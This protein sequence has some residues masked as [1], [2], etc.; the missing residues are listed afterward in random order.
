MEAALGTERARPA[1]GG[2]GDE[3]G[4]F[5]RRPAF[6]AGTAL[7]VLAFAGLFFRW[8][9]QQHRFS[10]KSPSDWG[11]AYLIP[12][13]SCYLLWQH[14]EALGRARVRPN[15]LGLVVLA[16]GILSHFAFI[17][18]FPNHMFQG[19]ALV[20]S[21]MGVTLLM[22]GTEVMRHAFLPIAY[23]GFG[24][25]LS[26]KLMIMITFKLQAVASWGAWVLLSVVSPLMGFD[27]QRNG[28]VL[29]VT[30]SAGVTN[31]LNV[32]EQCSGMRMVVAFV[33]LGTAV[34]LI[35][36]RKWWRRIVVVLSAIPVA[37]FLNVVRVA[38]LGIVTLFDPK[39]A[40]GAA[41]TLIGTI[42]LIPGL[43]LFLLIVWILNRIVVDTGS[44]EGRVAWR[45]G[46][47]TGPRRT[48]P[49]LLAS[50]L[51]LGVSATA[52]G[53]AIDAMEIRLQKL[54]VHPESG[55]MLKAIPAET[56]NWVRLGRDQIQDVEIL[57]TLG[58]ENEV[59][60]TYQEKHA[61]EGEKPRRVEFHAT[62][63]TGMIDT[64]PHV[65]ERCFV[66][67]GLQIV[68]GARV[69]PLKLD[70][71]SWMRDPEA[72]EVHGRPMFRAWTSGG[73]DGLTGRVRVRLPIGAEETHIR[74]GEYQDPGSGTKLF[75]G[76]FFI[77]NGEVVW[78]AEAVRVRA[79][80]LKADYAYYAKV[81]FT[82]G[83]L[84]GIDSAEE[85]VEVAS[86]VMNDLYGDL[87]ECLPDWTKVRQGQWPANNPRRAQSR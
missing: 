17:V 59:S 63:Y 20:L 31:P 66:G 34:A 8:F 62:Y 80:N 32:A 83:T 39:L 51:V 37:I 30:D 6:A 33:A 22:L 70:T 78:S 3:L 40:Q 55:R 50:L 26:Q 15:W 36:C 82:G 74:V 5:A 81:Q 48:V 75:A 7:I 77:A 18:V 53:W 85:L 87:M 27:V 61:P 41:H 52:M 60:R 65:P 28:N 72:T 69:M 68:K 10:M 19:I 49:A 16:V 64:V 45:A 38:V 71:A 86:S 14:R 11:H 9:E 44:T 23:L 2:G 4:H 84:H 73:A 54:P 79:F 56:P 13:I 76:Y 35:A 24:I 47:E 21:I 57:E 42:L 58:T 67:G 43:G 29:F 46:R 1:E 25:T 12:L